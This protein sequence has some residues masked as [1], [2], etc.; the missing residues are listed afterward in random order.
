MSSSQQNEDIRWQQRFNNFKKA[1][2][3][4]NDAVELAQK[5]PLSPLE[6]QGMIKAFEFTQELAWKVIKDY[7]QYQGYQNITG[8]RD[9]IRTAFQNHIIVDGETWMETIISCNKTAHTYDEETVKALL[10]TI[11]SRYMKLFNQFMQKM[12]SLENDHS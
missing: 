9:A 10:E 5:R 3:R 1:Y 11:S 12:G 4:L 8:S 6:Q 2:Q 7:L